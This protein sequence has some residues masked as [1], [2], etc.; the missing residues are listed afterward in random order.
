VERKSLAY[1]SGKDF[2]DLALKASTNARIDKWHCIELKTDAQQKKQCEQ[3]TYR[4][5]NC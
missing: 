3:T 1:S 2:L 4:M 5:E